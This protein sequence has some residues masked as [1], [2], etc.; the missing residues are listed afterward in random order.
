MAGASGFLGTRL[1]RHLRA[2]G[3][4]VTRLVRRE[5]SGA[6]ELRWD[7]ARRVLDPSVLSTVDAVINLAGANVGRPWT[8]SYKRTLLAS[9]IDTTATIATAIATGDHKPALLLNASGV[10]F[11]GDTGDRTVD[12]TAPS[13][14]GFLAGMCR[15]WE[16]ATEPAAQAGAR[17]VALRTG[18]P[19]DSAG[20]LLKPTLLQFRLFAGG[21][22]GSGRQYLPWIALPD[23]LGAVSLLLERDDIAGPVNLTGPDPVPNAEFTRTLAA[24]LHRPAVL[25]VPGPAL[26]MLGDLGRSLLDSLRVL[27]GVL[28][29]AGYRFRYPDVESALRQAVEKK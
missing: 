11:Y 2:G 19:L 8:A 4:E 26:R 12:E 29:G 23:W 17:V 7:P 5:P 24:V 13:G 28:T 15:R 21:R 14:E 3:H 16:A 18:F 1:A 10:H 27:P 9:R 6:G 25:P 22:L 20:G